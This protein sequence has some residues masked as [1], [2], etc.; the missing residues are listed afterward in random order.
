MNKK[1][2][3]VCDPDRDYAEVFSHFVDRKEGGRFDVMAFT[4]PDALREYLSYG[5]FDILVVS[6]AF[7]ES[8]EGMNVP[9]GEIPARS[10]YILSEE[11]ETC[12]FVFPSIYK[13]QSTEKILK[14][15][16]QSYD[17]KRGSMAKKGL[18]VRITGIYS[19]VKRCGKTTLSLCLSRILAEKKSVLYLNFEELC[20][21]AFLRKD[22]NPDAAGISDV[23][24]RCAL[25]E[26]SGCLSDIEIQ[27]HDGFDYLAAPDCPDDIHSADCSILK[28]I[29]EE[30][31]KTGVYREIIIDLG[32]ALAEPEK[33]LDIC[34]EI[35]MPVSDDE[36]GSAKADLWQ[37]YMLERGYEDFGEK[38]SRIIIRQG[39]EERTARSVLKNRT[40]KDARRRES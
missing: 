27:N 30:F 3:G 23:L 40:E 2:F 26:P 22:S 9:E 28:F 6:E 33:V 15:I 7:I 4:K 24:Y 18:P 25:K 14:Q 36:A 5:G 29:V 17:K 19:P 10:T 11:R 12:G 1:I 38:T 37:K 13:Y 31:S 16:M 8:G 34:D 39:E 21:E 35:I 32:D 20:G